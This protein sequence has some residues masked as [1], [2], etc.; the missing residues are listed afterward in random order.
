MNL[1]LLATLGYLVMIVVVGLIAARKSMG[2]GVREFFVAGANLSW[3]LLLP[4]VGAEFASSWIAVGNAEMAHK[5]GIAVLMYFVGTPIGVLLTVFVLSAFYVRLRMVSVGEVFGVLFDQKTRLAFAVFRLAVSWFIM[6]GV[7]LQLA[8]I[9]GPMFN[10]PYATA[11]FL[12]AAIIA[13]L[14]ILGLRSLAWMNLIHFIVLIVGFAIA[15]VAAVNAVGGLGNLLASLPPEHLNLFAPGRATTASWFIPRI[16]SQAI[17]LILIMTFFAAKDLK[18]ARVGAVAGSMIIFIVVF[19]PMTIGLCARVIFPEIESKYALWEM[20]NYLGPVISAL[21]SIATIACIISTTP[22]TLLANTAM[23]TRD[24]FLLIRP[25]ANERAQMIFSRIFCVVYIITGTWLVL[26]ET[27]MLMIIIKASQTR[28]FLGFLI[29]ISVLWRRIHATAAFLTII[30]SAGVGLV[31]WVAGSPF[32]ISVMWPVLIV[33]SLTL[34]IASLIKR[35]SPYKGVEG[36]NVILQPT[37][38]RE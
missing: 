3:F 20:G 14:A 9:L 22:G 17:S 26:G 7:A 10:M 13:F 5:T 23:A 8:A 24:I 27:S 18:N 29:I 6:G 25:E 19:L 12:S 37:G 35:P 34:I 31:W 2:Q 16:P 33:G 32:G 30:M 15:T 28:F 11:A 4:F 1:A 21:I 38:G 36:L